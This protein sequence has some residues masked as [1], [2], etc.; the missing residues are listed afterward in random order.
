MTVNTMH[1]MFKLLHTVFDRD[2]GI[3]KEEAA[4]ITDSISDIYAISRHNDMAHLVGFALEQ[5]GL[6]SEGDACFSKFQKEQ[7]MAVYRQENQDY[8]LDRTCDALE[9]A[10]IPF[11]PLKGAVLRRIYPEPWMR[12]SCDIDILVKKEDFDRAKKCMLDTLGYRQGKESHHDEAFDSQGGA[13]IE[14]HFDLLEENETAQA[15]SVIS[16]VW[17]RSSVADGRKYMYEMSDEMFYFYH[18]AH[19]AKHVEYGGIGFRSF[20]DL[21]LLEGLSEKKEERRDELIEVGGLGI[22]RKV[23][24]ELTMHWMRGEELSDLGKRAEIFILNCGTYGSQSNGVLLGR[25]KSGGKG[26]YLFSRIF[27]PYEQIKYSFPI[28]KKHKWLLPFCQIARWFKLLSPKMA[29]SASSELR[30]SMHLT[31]KDLQNMKLLLS[32]MGLTKTV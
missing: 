10:E 12:T 14:L 27:M 16:E 22:F 17:K 31:E 2:I 20:L 21:F 5:N 8:E 4:L 25:E 32:D 6:I 7:F 15:A 19:M 29:K 30:A 23:A 3:S 26:Q 13:H 24:R 18:I 28:L 9:N 1:A 11:I